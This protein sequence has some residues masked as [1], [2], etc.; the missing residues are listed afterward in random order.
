LQVDR[1]KS[2]P[3]DDKQSLKGAW[4]RYVTHFKFL[5][6]PKNISGMAYATDF[7][8]FYTGWP[9]EVLAFG[10]TNSPSSERDHSHV[11]SLYFGK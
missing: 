1:S 11:T 3:I 2:K 7:I 9:C 5:V 8:F 4:S 6:P 10:L